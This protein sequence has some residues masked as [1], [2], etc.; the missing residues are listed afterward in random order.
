MSYSYKGKILI[1]TPDLSGDV[2]SRSVVLILDH[3]SEG[4]FGLILN[5][6]R[7][8]TVA[9]TEDSLHDLKSELYDGGPVDPNRRFV[10][11][12]GEPKDEQCI[13]INQEFYVTEDARSVLIQLLDEKL[14]LD[15][16]KFFSG[17]SGWLS[18]QLESEISRKAWTVVDIYNLDYTTKNDRNLWKKVMQ[19]L[20][21]EFLLWANSPEDITMN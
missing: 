14:N 4:A 5:K 2:F 6:K 20:G 13:A 17:Y 3:S 15:D 9:L 1:S 7:Q 11:V 18:G 16:I 8:D 10:I 12:K 21:G 19:N